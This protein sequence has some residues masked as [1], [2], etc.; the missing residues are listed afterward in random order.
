MRLPILAALS[1]SLLPMAGFGQQSVTFAVPGRASR[2]NA[3]LY[4]SGSKYVILAH[5]GR[6]AKESWKRQAESL[7]GAGFAALAVRYRGD[8]VHPD[9]SPNAAGSNSDN[10]EDVIAAV[11]YSY[12]QGA[13]TV[14]GVGGSLG[15]DALGEADAKLEP[16]RISRIVILGSS[17]GS[18]PEKLTGR[19]LFIVAR[20][21]RSGSGLRL[22]EIRK[23]FERVPEPK[24][25][26][27]LDGSAHAQFLF[28]TDQGSTVMDQIFRFF[29]EP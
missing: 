22:P 2:V 15:G 25:L 6:F 20:D 5:G 16:G 4:G 7:A 24:K 12:A 21:D 13:T 11:T 28:D 23:H 17:G 8:T 3:D 14:F 9:G 27:V 18:A 19:K 10:A 1:I 26:V 29:Q